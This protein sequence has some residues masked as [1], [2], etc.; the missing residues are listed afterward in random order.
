[1]KRIDMVG[2]RYGH[3]VVTKMLYDYNKNRETFCECKCDCG[4]IVLKN[5]GRLRSK[6]VYPKNCGCLK[7]KR[8]DDL[9]NM[10]R[11][12]LTGRRFGRLVVT[13]MIF[14][15]NKQT[16]AECVCD[17]GSRIRTKAVYL[18]NGDT[19]SC[20]CLQRDATSSANTKDFSGMKSD[21]GVVFIKRHSQTSRGVW[22]WECKC[23]FCGESFVALPAKV[24]EGNVISC[25]CSR[26]SSGEAYIK[27]LL[28]SLGVN[29][30]AEKRFNNCRD[31]YT[32]PF[33]FYLPDQNVAIEFQGAQHYRP[34]EWFGGVDGFM[35]RVSHDEI[36][37]K[38]CDENNIK[39]IHISY[40]DSRDE[41]SEKIT[42]IIYPER[43]SRFV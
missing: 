2:N 11:E 43:L 32:L 12:D 15:K 27:D 23:G 19:K 41:I 22:L 31:V 17:C 7:Q 26:I 20:G 13:E 8:M 36:K 21:F 24:L 40:N 28:C 3:L 39:L 42:S 5:A 29:Y 1:M 38:F 35:K 34:V 18:K 30:V 9:A 16:L 37:Q 4:N 25:G 6:S 14:E 10:L 33:D